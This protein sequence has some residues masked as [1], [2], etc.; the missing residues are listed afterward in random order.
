M[1]SVY[2]AQGQLHGVY[3][4]THCWTFITFGAHHCGLFVPTRCANS[5]NVCLGKYLQHYIKFAW[6]I[7]EIKTGQIRSGVWNNRVVRPSPA[8]YTNCPITH[9]V[10]QVFAHTALQCCI[11]HGGLLKMWTK[12]SFHWSLPSLVALWDQHPAGNSTWPR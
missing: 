8:P 11:S 9:R 4:C 5:A 12:S 2:P 7:G 10:L 1:P 3:N 6:Q